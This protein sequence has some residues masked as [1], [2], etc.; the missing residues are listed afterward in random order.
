MEAC[1]SS[2]T[3]IAFAKSPWMFRAV[4]AG[5]FFCSANRPCRNAWLAPL[6]RSSVL[7][8]TDTGCTGRTGGSCTLCLVSVAV[9]VAVAVTVTVAVAESFGDGGVAILLI[10]LGVNDV[11]GGFLE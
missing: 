9:A 5:V 2:A 7:Y 10:E 8:A 1:N 11:R 3:P 4:R 6:R